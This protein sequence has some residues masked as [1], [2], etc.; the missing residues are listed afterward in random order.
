[1]AGELS[2]VVEGD[3]SAQSWSQPLDHGHQVRDGL[4]CCLAYQG[5]YQGPAGFALMQ[6]QQRPQT[7]AVDQISFSVA[8]LCALIG[9]LCSL[10]YMHCL[11]NAVF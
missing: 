4:C 7:L 3:R 11:G 2:A 8:Y 1:M 5:A 10:G 9:S 6:Y